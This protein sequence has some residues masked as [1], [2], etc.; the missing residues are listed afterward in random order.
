MLKLPKIFGFP[1]HGLVTNGTLTLPNNEQFTHPGIT[2]GDTQLLAVP[3]FPLVTRTPEQQA[4]D[5]ANG[6]EW[7]NKAIIANNHLGSADLGENWLLYIDSNQTTW[8]FNIGY[9]VVGNQCSFSCVLKSAFGRFNGN[10]PQISRELAQSQTTFTEQGALKPLNRFTFERSSNGSEMLIHVYAELIEDNDIEFPEPLSLFEVWK[11]NISGDGALSSNPNELGQGIAA[12]FTRFKSFD[13]IRQT[14]AQVIPKESQYFNVG[15]IITSQRYEPEDAQP[16]E[17]STN[18]YYESWDLELIPDGEPYTPTDYDRNRYEQSN[19]YGNETEITSVVRYVYDADN[20]IHSLSSKRVA[21]Q[22]NYI[23]QTFSGS[24][25]G[26]R[27]PI[28]YFF[29]GSICV[30]NGALPGLAEENTGIQVTNIQ[31]QQITEVSL[32][33]DDIEI[34]TMSLMGE[35]NQ[36]SVNNNATVGVKVTLNGQTVRDYQGASG[37]IPPRIFADPFSGTLPGDHEDGIYAEFKQGLLCNKLMAN[38]M[39]HFISSDQRFSSL[40]VSRAVVGPNVSDSN[41]LDDNHNYYLKGSYDPIS[42]QIV[43]Y[44]FGVRC[45]V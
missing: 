3:N 23:H 31:S 45:W 33:L 2:N 16:P 36:S 44:K 26:Q 12:S 27:G 20:Q 13:D 7:R 14:N 29:N 28:E 21:K 42:T 37:S 43:R 25:T 6:F 24:G 10:Y 11:L 34:D 39:E 30:I 41:V 1:Y 17:C 38:F 32:L 19:W 9:N 15:R 5:Q 4:S 40:K 8:Y 22:L 35:T 18:T